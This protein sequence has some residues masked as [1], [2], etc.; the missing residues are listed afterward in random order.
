[1]E[2]QTKRD[3]VVVRATAVARSEDEL[4]VALEAIAPRQIRQV[5]WPV[6]IPVTW[7]RVDAEVVRRRAQS[8]RE[9]FSKESAGRLAP[10]TLEDDR[11]ARVE[12]IRRLFW[13]EPQQSAPGEPFLSGFSVVFEAPDPDARSVVLVVPFVALN[14]PEHSVTVHLRD[15]PVDVALG[16]HRFRVLSTEAHGADQRKVIMEIPPSTASPRFVQPRRMQGAEPENIAWQSE[17]VAAESGTEAIWMATK[18]GDPPIVTFTGAVLQVDGPF[19]L[20]LSLS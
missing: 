19:R 20:E 6:P 8:L 5:G 2:V 17:P 16:E 14:D 12:E 18:V 7:S 13:M 4:V 15:A 1:L 3:G 9:H 10:I 11:G